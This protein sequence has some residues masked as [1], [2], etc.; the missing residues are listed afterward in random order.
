MS[1]R[2]IAYLLNDTSGEKHIGSSLVI[3]NLYR[4]CRNLGVSITKTF[5]RKD[6]LGEKKNQLRTPGYDFIIVNGEGTLHHSPKVTEDLLDIVGNKPRILVNS[7]WEKMYCCEKLLSKFSFISVRE[8]SSYNEIIKSFPEGKVEIV[9]DLV[10]FNY[11]EL[12][13]EQKIGYGDSVMTA[14][15]NQLK[16]QKNFFPM[17]NIHSPTTGA[18]ISWMRSLDLYITGR[19]H[20]VC[21][22]IA[23]G[24]PFLA[25]PSNSHKIEGILNDCNC[26]E[27]LIE[28]FSE[29]EK[30]KDLAI[31]AVSKTQEYAKQAHKK[32]MDFYSKIFSS[33]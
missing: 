26:P 13:K 31:R 5:T 22:A 12:V 32:I 30:K 8:S 17:Q 19:F 6:L 14:V 4:L 21:L 11:A 28:N 2:K 27:L 29:V 20:G 23:T 1:E 33:I 15:C 16:A 24:V 10:F 7:L 18:Y 3:H 9:P 25:L